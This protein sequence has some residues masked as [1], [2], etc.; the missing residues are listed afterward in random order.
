MEGVSI[1]NIILHFKSRRS[2]FY[3]L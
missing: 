3:G 2:H 1:M